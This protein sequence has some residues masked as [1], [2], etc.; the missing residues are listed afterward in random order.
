ML[1]AQL[2]YGGY[3]TYHSAQDLQPSVTSLSE[4]VTSD[5]SVSTASFGDHIYMQLPAHLYIEH[6]LCTL[7]GRKCKC[8]FFFIALIYGTLVPALAFK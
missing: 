4:L 3:W 8:C 7:H 6:I 5:S 1:V 2:V